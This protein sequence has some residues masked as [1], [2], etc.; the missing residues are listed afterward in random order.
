MPFRPMSWRSK[1]SRRA[2]VFAMGQRSRSTPARPRPL[3]RQ[4]RRHQLTRSQHR[5]RPRP[6]LEEPHRRRPL[7]QLEEPHRRRPLP[8]LE[9]PHRRRPRQHHPRL[10]I[11]SERL[12]PL[13]NRCLT[14]DVMRRFGGLYLLSRSVPVTV[15]GPESLTRRVMRRHPVTRRT[16]TAWMPWSASVRSALGARGP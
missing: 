8:Q 10:G 13:A 14:S 4:L 5:L 7:P 2:P 9:E 16:W 6:Q 15:R 3:H 1:I 11:V 12:P